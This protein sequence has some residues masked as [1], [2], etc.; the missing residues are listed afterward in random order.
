MRFT[1]ALIVVLAAVPAAA[2][3]TVVNVI[4]PGAG[5]LAAKL[6]VGTLAG[7]QAAGVAL[8]RPRVVA[9]Y[10]CPGGETVVELHHPGDAVGAVGRTAQFAIV[11]ASPGRPL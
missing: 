1:S 8:D 6:R 10:H 5:P 3:S 11:P 2:D 7:C 4:R 9:R